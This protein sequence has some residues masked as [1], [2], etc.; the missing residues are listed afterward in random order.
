MQT[1]ELTEVGMWAM[2]YIVVLGIPG[3]IT[4][5]NIVN[6]FKKKRIKPKLM[7]VLTL[8]IGLWDY[9]ILF[10]VVA[11]M[12]GDYYQ[13]I[14]ETQVHNVLYSEKLLSF[15]LPCIAGLT[16]LL[17]L[18]LSPAKKLP[19]LAAV[20][21]I[22]AVIIGN[23]MNVLFAIQIS[24]NDYNSIL[25]YVFHLNILILSI[26]CMQRQIKAQVELIKERE[27]QFRHG[28]MNKV[29][30]F[31]TKASNMCML[32][33][34]CVLP[35]ALILWVILLLFGQGSDGV[36]QVFTMTADW[37]FSTQIPPPSLYSEGHYL[38]TV[39]A[40]GHKK[41]VKPLRMGKRRGQAIVVNR[42]LCIANAFE[43]LI[44]DKLPRFHKKVRHFYDTYGYPLS[45][46][47]TTKSRADI[48]Y[49][50]MKPLE[51]IFLAVLYLFDCNPESRI[52][53]QYTC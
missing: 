17:I 50:V 27:T 51:W 14:Y 5:L 40:G 24:S 38:C 8:V 45:K 28:W 7:L 32:S 34:L 46:K 22:A 30:G 23:V 18:G 29:Y 20:F 21:A 4:I 42:Q 35:L 6:L 19:P 1:R 13:V 12:K 33:F 16:G 31:L 49:I 15:V 44:Q 26:Q 52:A 11:D 3:V 36:I 41:V 53:K 47:I 9:L 2:I 25:F 10:F 39:A 43:E 48:V 37:T